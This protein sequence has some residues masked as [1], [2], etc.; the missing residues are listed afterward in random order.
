MGIGYVVVNRIAY[1][2]ASY[3]ALHGFLT[4][5]CGKPLY[6]DG[7]VSVY[8]LTRTYLSI[9]PG[10]LV[11]LGT[12]W[13]APA[14][15]K[16]EGVLLRFMSQDGT[17]RVIGVDKPR[18]VRLVMGILSPFK[19]IR[20]LTVSVNGKVINRIDLTAN[21]QPVLGWM[22]APFLLARGNNTIV[23][24]SINSPVDPYK[25]IGPLIQDP[26]PVSIGVFG[27]KISDTTT[28]KH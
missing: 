23:I 27:V 13:Y 21:K 3:N 24:H 10:E 20:W 4:T 7:Y 22:S 6:D 16:K 17:I 25:E 1:D 8:R 12:G 2:Q 14:L 9:H 19:S 5:Y 11:E 26:R 15:D 18:T 28:E